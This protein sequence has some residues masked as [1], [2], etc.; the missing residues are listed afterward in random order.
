MVMAAAGQ[1][2]GRSALSNPEAAQRCVLR[3]CPRRSVAATLVHMLIDE[4]LE[5]LSD[6]EC[7]RLLASQSVGRVGVS[8]AALPAILPVNYSMVDG[9]VVFRTG[10]GVKLR[11]ALHGNVVAFEVD[12]SDSDLHEGWSVL[13]IG[14]AEVVTDPVER[15]RC[16]PPTSWAGGDRS[17][18]VRIRPE[19]ISGRRLVP[20]VSGPV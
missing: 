12:H 4:G 14:L 1:R 8:M 10:D 11:A 18:V 5:L 20:S 7:R 3:P 16:I 9:A 13:V 17:H 15:D 6:E 2:K 19:L